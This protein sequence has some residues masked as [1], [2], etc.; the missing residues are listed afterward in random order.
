MNPKNHNYYIHYIDYRYLMCIDIQ[1]SA[2]HSIS[3][4]DRIIM[5]FVSF[6][7]FCQKISRKLENI[8]MVMKILTTGLSWLCTSMLMP[9][10][11]Y[12]IW[13]NDLVKLSEEVYV[14]YNKLILYV[15]STL[16]NY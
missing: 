12:G 1:Y 6:G 3:T 13:V 15:Y 10:V 5:I 16:L 14:V 7:N 8:L 9:V 4:V 2:S 11:C